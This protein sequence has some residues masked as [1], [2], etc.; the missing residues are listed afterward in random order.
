MDIGRSKSK[1]VRASVYNSLYFP[2]RDLV[3]DSSWGFVSGSIMDS[4]WI[5]AKNLIWA[6]V[7]NSVV[8][9]VTLNSTNGNR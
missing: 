1:S 9:S 7:L 8:D 3:W 5:S 2:V 6:L 4:L